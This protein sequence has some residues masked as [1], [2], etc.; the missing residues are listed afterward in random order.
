MPWQGMAQS[1]KQLK[2]MGFFSARARA[3]AFVERVD[4]LEFDVGFDAIA[5]HARLGLCEGGQA[6]RACSQP[7]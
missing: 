3:K 4:I 5:I 2:K 6:A 1:A 7:N